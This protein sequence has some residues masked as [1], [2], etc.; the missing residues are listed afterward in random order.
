MNDI[1]VHN[2]LLKKLPDNI[3]NIILLFRPS[4][5]YI[6]ELNHIKKKCFDEYKEWLDDDDDVVNINEFGLF[7]LLLESQNCNIINF[8]TFSD[9]FNFDEF[10]YNI[11]RE[12]I[13]IYD[14]YGHEIEPLDIPDSI[15]EKYL[16]RK[17]DKNYEKNYRIQC[18][19]DG[20]FADEYIEI[21][22]FRH[23]FRIPEEQIIKYKKRLRIK[24]EEDEDS[25]Y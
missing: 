20:Y 14:Y 2:L 22:F 7:E 8:K 19:Y 25:Y 4:H 1:E 5:N 16:E 21:P 17:N 11:Y 12:Y 15:I 9:K 6:K 13:C 18:I 23:E 10:Y 3:C 24:V